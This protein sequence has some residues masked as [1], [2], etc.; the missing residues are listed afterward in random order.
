M[1]L[2]FVLFILFAWLIKYPDTIPAPVE[3]TTTNPPVTLVTK[4]TGNINSFFVKER[5]KVSAGQ[6]VAVMETTAS[7]HEIELLKQTIDTIKEPELQSYRLLPLFSDLGELQGYYGTFLKNLSD[8]NNYVINV[9][10][11]SKIASLNDEI[12]G[13][14][15]FINRLS[16]KEKLYSENQRLETKKFNRDSSLFTGKVIPES[17]FETSHQSLLKVNID[18]QQARLDHSAKSIELAEKRQ[19][20][21]DYRITMI[22]EKEKLVSVLRESFLNLKAQ[23]NLWENTYLLISPIEGIVSFTKFWSANQSVVKDEPV[24]SIVPVETGN[25]LGRINLPMQRSGKVK[26]GQSVN[27]KLSGYPYLQYGMVRGIVKS[28]SLVPAGDTYVIEIELPEGLSTL[29]GTKL[30]FTQNMQGTAE[31]ITENIRLL[32][33]IV[34]PFRYM[35]SK[36]RK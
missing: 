8:L 27:I 33:K 5:E 32:Q 7:L 3:I 21:E 18:L 30:D 17:E 16:V 29:Y 2:I 11:G 26:K 12:K 13:I 35:V 1:L 23:I 9:F 20:L 15:E 4:I 36:N 14:Q 22:N 19:L 25:F 34:N 28:K 31:I 6:L 24:V 10:N